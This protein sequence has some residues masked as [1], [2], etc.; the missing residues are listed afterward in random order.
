[1][2]AC[3][4]CPARIARVDNPLYGN[5]RSGDCHRHAGGDDHREGAGRVGAHLCIGG[6]RTDRNRHPRRAF[7]RVEQ[8]RRNHHRRDAGN[9]QRRSAHGGGVAGDLSLAV[10]RNY[11]WPGVTPAR[12]AGRSSPRLSTPHPSWRCSFP[13]P[14]NSSSIPESP[15]RGVLLPIAHATTLAGSATL[16]GTSA[17]LLIGGLAAPHGVR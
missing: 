12:P 11:P 9:C 2:K 16:I 3:E 14:T 8:W 1:M 6:G 13:P 17:N 10:R 5:C 4:Q 7:R 15:A